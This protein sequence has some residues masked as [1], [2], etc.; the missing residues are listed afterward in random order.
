MT[1][2]MYPTDQNRRYDSD[3]LTVA[4]LLAAGTFGELAEIETRYDRYKNIPAVKLWKEAP[5]P[6]AGAAYD[7]GS[8]LVDQLLILFGKPDKVTAILS[9]SRT[10]GHPDVPDAFIIHRQFVVVGSK[11]LLIYS[12]QSI[13]LLLPH[14][15]DRS[16]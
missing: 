13:M 2:E 5:L 9:N 7:L 10:I 3:F 14:L 6:G 8:H 1:D 4:K 11:Q 12:R 15:V 16:P